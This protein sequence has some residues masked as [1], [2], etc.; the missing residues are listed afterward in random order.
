MLLKNKPAYSIILYDGFY[1]LINN[2]GGLYEKL[3]L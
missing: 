1:K 2:T 3:F